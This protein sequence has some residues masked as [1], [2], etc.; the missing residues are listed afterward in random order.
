[1]GVARDPSDDQRAQDMRQPRERHDQAHGQNVIAGGE[2]E[3]RRLDHGEQRLET[4]GQRLAVDRQ[5]AP[6]GEVARHG[7]GV[8]A[9]LGERHVVDMRRR[10]QRQREQRRRG[11]RAQRARCEQ[12]AARR[13]D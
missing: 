13:I 4:V 1:M 12:K 9:V 7:E 8:I 2:C 6:G 11:R 10:P 3:R 5:A